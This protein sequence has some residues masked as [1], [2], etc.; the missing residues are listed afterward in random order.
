MKAF[1]SRLHWHCHFMQKFESETRIEFEPLNLGY[2]DFPYQAND[3]FLAAWMSGNTG[4]PL[5]DA[6][7]RCLNQT[8]YMNFRMRAL[9]VSVLCHHANIDWRAGAHHLARQFLDFEPGIHYPQ[10]QM[11]AGVTGINTL[12]IYNPVKQALE[13][14]PDGLFLRRW[15]PELAALPM[16]LLAQPWLL[17][18]MEAQMYQIDPESR[19]LNPLIDVETEAAKA[20]DRLWSWRKRVGVQRYKQ[21]I[22]SRHVKSSR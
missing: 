15:L 8:G 19:Y 6:C 18:A 5:V 3:E 10:I 2:S 7:M 21:R 13:H 12:R 9:L 22:L 11:Q 16:P 17:T 1:I 14:D 20:R 4:I